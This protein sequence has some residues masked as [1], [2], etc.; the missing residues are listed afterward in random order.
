MLGCS[1]KLRNSKLN[2]PTPKVV[3]TASVHLGF[4]DC[5]LHV[6]LTVFLSETLALLL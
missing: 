3:T 2:D 6:T 1:R 5:E 4:T